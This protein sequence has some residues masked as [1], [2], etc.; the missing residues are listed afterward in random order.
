M[1]TANE[2]LEWCLKNLTL[3]DADRR[4]VYAQLAAEPSPPARVLVVSPKPERK[5]ETSG[6]GPWIIGVSAVTDYLQICG[7]PIV[8]SGDDYDLAEM[9]LAEIAQKIVERDRPGDGRP[10]PDNCVQYRG[11]R[12]MR[13]RLLVSFAGERPRL[14]KVQPDHEGRSG[15]YTRSQPERKKGGVRR[16]ENQSSSSSSNRR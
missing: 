8:S 15:A 9:E 11:P 6:D 14:V 13:L 1:K 12:P 5:T 7:R 3:S 16:R 2:A 4:K 10:M